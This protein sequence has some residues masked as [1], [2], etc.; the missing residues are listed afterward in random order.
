MRPDRG[1]Y[2]YQQAPVRDDAR[3]FDSGLQ[4]YMRKVYGV[5]GR[6]LLA[7]GGVA[8]AV[9]HIEPL[10]NLIFGTPLVW[11][12]M[13]APLGFIFFGFSAKALTKLTAGQVRTR[14]Y[15]F[16]AVFG[17]S[18]ASIFMVFT[19]ASIARVFFIT[20][21][22]FAAISLFGYTTKKD[23]TGMGSF[24]MMGLIGLIIAMVV[25][26]FLASAMI[27]FI[28][29]AAGVLIFTGLIAYESQMLKRMYFNSTGAED[30]DKTATMGALGLLISF[31]N[32]F[33]FLM[34][35]LGERQ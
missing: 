6:G 14:Y 21:A 25:N 31:V 8:Y 22:M 15:L 23:L 32:L 5:L 12:A 28:T 1:S 24:L 33:Q 19:G 10:R 18:L 3:Q 2:E 11:V 34:H 27:H 29:S 20:S 35:F 13:L 16:A 7:T 30:L 4:T 17:I 26:L 9:A